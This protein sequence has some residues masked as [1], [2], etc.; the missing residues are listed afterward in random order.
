MKDSKGAT[1]MKSKN[2]MT[3]GS[4]IL[5]FAIVARE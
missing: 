3:A 1:A 5:R 2:K 4:L